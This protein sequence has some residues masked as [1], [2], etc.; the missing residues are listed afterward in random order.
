MPSEFH[1][2]WVALP[3]CLVRKPATFLH[4]YC[5]DN[6]L[7]CTTGFSVLWRLDGWS[8]SI[9]KCSALFDQVL[10]FTTCIHFIYSFFVNFTKTQIMYKIIV[11]GHPCI[12]LLLRLKISDSFCLFWH[13]LRSCHIFVLSDLVHTRSLCRALKIK[14]QPN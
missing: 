3:I 10:F 9:S 13:K 7:N 8:S 12:T 5:T 14:C 6:I 1:S 11:G 2:S 4:T